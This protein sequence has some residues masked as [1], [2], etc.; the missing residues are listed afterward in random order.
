[1]ED[2]NTKIEEKSKPEGMVHFVLSHSYSVFLFAVVLGVIIDI[3]IPISAFTAVRYQY[4]GLGMIF[5]GS[6]LIYWAQSTTSATK[7]EMEEE[8]A[9]RDFARGPYKY[10][11][12][13]THIGLTVMTLGLGFLIQSLFSV[14]LIIIAALITKFIFV[15]QEEDILEEKYGQSYCDYKKKVRTWV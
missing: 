3:V 1:M 10:S 5:L 7:K 15:K 14:V 8:G 2:Q 9:V 12:N 11:R 6:M 13:P 4:A